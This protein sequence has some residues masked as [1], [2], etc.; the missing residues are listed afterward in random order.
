MLLV[1]FCNNYAF[2]AMVIAG[3]IRY[4]KWE[5]MMM[6]EKFTRREFL[7]LSGKGLVSLAFAGAAL[8]FGLP[9]ALAS[10]KLSVN[11]LV[12]GENEMRVVFLKRIDE[13]KSDAF[14]IMSTTKDGMEIILIDGGRANRHCRNELLDLR[15][16]ILTRAGLADEIEKS[17]YLLHVTAIIS[18]FHGDHVNE[19]MENIVPY[20]HK[21][22]L[23]ALYYPAATA[24]PRKGEFNN[25]ANDDI[26][27]RY[28]L[29][30]SV[31]IQYA[32]YCEKHE[33]P[34]GETLDVP[35]K[36]GQLRLYAS[37]VDWGEG[38]YLQWMHDYH[39]ALKPQNIYGGMGTE[40]LNG[41]CLWA[42]MAYAGHSILF[43]GDTNKKF[44]DRTD[45]AYDLFIR[46]YGE[47]LRSDIV[48]FPHHGRGRDAAAQP[49]KDYL[50][51]D[52][53]MAACILSGVDG[54]ELAGAALTPLNVKWY[55]LNTSDVVYVIDENGLERMV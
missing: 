29:L 15:R 18:H 42:R 22:R 26:M 48:K 51:T 2:S 19:L 39:F 9:G 50:M 21:I 20:S 34:F 12:T 37:P 17:T 4:N 46:K 41:N 10:G 54:P 6:K 7:C 35:T 38:E 43:T 28:K 3:P 27:K 36:L 44:A 49:T 32:R 13:N 52:D 40:V 25:N 30:E 23:D 47:E 45:E 55:D 8:K 5:L 16:E 53:P 31:K 11:A 24:L 14:Y 1:F 33:I